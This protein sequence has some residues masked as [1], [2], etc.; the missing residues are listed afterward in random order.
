G[1]CVR[2]GE[3]ALRILAPVPLRKRADGEEPAPRGK[4]D[5]Q[6][7]GRVAFRAAAVFDR[8]QVD[9]LPDVDPTPVGAPCEPLSGDSHAHLLE[10]LRAFCVDELGYT[11]VLRA[12]QGPVGGWCDREARELVV[13]ARGPANAQLRVLVHETAHALGVNYQTHGR[14]H[15]EVIVDCTTYIVCASVGLDVGGESIPYVAGWGEDDQVGAVT[16]FA[17]VIDELAR[18]LED[19]LGAHAAPLAGGGEGAA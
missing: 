6:E 17:G 12:L 14:A 13:D 5:D 9:P 10:P 15:A 11:V 7:R 2:R 1:Y 4:S 19:V 18:R 8:S 3:R 16:E